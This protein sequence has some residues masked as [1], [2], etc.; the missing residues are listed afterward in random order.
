MAQSK[1]RTTKKAAPETKSA[2]K[3][4]KRREIGALLC[5]LLAI[6]AVIGYFGGQEA[7]FINFFSLF[8][9]GLVGWGAFAVAP[10]LLF[11]SGILAFHK[12]MPVRFRTVCILL[13]PLML[14]S[15]LHLFLCD[16]QYKWSF[17]MLGSM[18]K[19]GISLESG[20]MI[21]GLLAL[22][23]KAMFSTA[24][25]AVV[26]IGVLVFLVLASANRTIADIAK[27]IKEREKVEYMPQPEQPAAKRQTAFVLSEQHSA[28]PSIDIPIDEPPRLNKR[29]SGLFNRTPLVP[30]PD[31]LIK[32]EVDLT[33]D[34]PVSTSQLHYSVPVAP[35]EP[36]APPEPVIDTPKKEV[37]VKK[38]KPEEIAAEE[39]A[40][41]RSVE[42]KNDSSKDYEFPPISL[43]KSV[44]SFGAVDGREEMSMNAA[45]LEN[46]IRSFGINA[47]INNI[48]RGP[49]VT[50]YEIELEQG[51]KLNRLTNLADDIALSL[52][53]TGVRIAPIPDKI[54]IVGIEVPNKQVAV[55]CLR[56]II[57]SNAFKSSTSK[58]SFAIGKDIGGSSVVGNIEKLPHMLIAGTTGSGKSVCMNSLI[59]SLL[60]KA[61]PDEVRLIMIDPKM[62][63][64]GVY[65]GI[66]HLLIP[67]VTDPKKAAGALQWAVNEM[68]KRYRL[69]AEMGARDI[70]SY[71]KMI[72]SD[73]D[74]KKLPQV[75][76]VIDELADLMLVAAKEVEESICRI[77][78]MAR[79]A[80]MHLIIATQRPSADVITGIMKANIPSRIA[81][82]V[83]SAM[84]SR[85]ILDTQGAEKLVGRGDMLYFPL[86]AG[87][88]VR[89]QGTL[90]DG[91]EVENVVKFVKQSSTASYSE[92]IISEIERHAEDKKGSSPSAG[93][94]EAKSRQDD[95]V[96]ELYTAA[97]EV[98][99]ESGQASVSMLQRR[100]KLGYSRAARLVDQMEERGIVGPFE[101]S[102]PRQLLIT[103]E[104]W[105]EMQYINGTAPILDAHEPEDYDDEEND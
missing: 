82:A 12:C 14:G 9:K 35:P 38:L 62:I 11:A 40:I 81:F 94:E 39:A 41:A 54:S 60:Y 98:I 102:K 30:A 26:F 61:K 90:I 86:G 70:H 4:P 56:E 5:L 76:I 71:N 13:V 47:R 104:Q 2:P 1:K 95:G 79:A 87:K 65:N 77:A 51:V 44:S 91:S 96:D 73:P 3:S 69:F 66:P 42:E 15:V 72:K 28:R 24:G 74:R 58:V 93:T 19:D 78:Q 89:V 20:G 36:A 50:R 43:L 22:G 29:K 80:G 101:G 75:V 103:K 17:G 85:I 100:L 49:S 88:P 16:L 46:T 52:G 84:E 92:E 67:V 21:G 57:E 10:A 27:K 68:M 53:A 8:M 59:I 45:R 63:E 32:G 6:F 33:K 18:Y 64:L 99:L 55:V 48:T 23:F 83:A 105:R 97:V 25:A 7:I 34:I 31:Q 37:A